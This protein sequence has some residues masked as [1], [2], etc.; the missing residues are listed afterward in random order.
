MESLQNGCLLV[1]HGEG[2]TAR[3][4]AGQAR[5]RETSPIEPVDQVESDVAR[6]RAVTIGDRGV[7]VGKSSIGVHDFFP[8]HPG[9]GGA[10]ASLS[11]C[12][13]LLNSSRPSSSFDEDG[14]GDGHHQPGPAGHRVRG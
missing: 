9:R 7:H 12:L 14:A 6:L 10:G 11:T 5:W 3:F 8:V 2:S 1:H 13:G 4:G